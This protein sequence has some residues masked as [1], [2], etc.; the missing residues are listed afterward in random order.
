LFPKVFNFVFMFEAYLAKF[1]QNHHTCL[2]VWNFL[3]GVALLRHSAQLLSCTF[4]LF[5]CL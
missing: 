5:Q 4:F 3:R 2:T 1:C